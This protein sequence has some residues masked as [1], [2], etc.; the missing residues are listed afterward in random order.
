M[1]GFIWFSK[2]VH[3]IKICKYFDYS[4][5]RSPPHAHSANRWLQA[6]KRH[7]RASKKYKIMKQKSRMKTKVF[8]ILKWIVAII[9]GFCIVIYFLNQGFKSKYCGFHRLY[10]D[11]I[12]N[13]VIYNFRLDSFNYCR[14]SDSIILSKTQ[15]NS[16]V[17]KWNNSYPILLCKYIPKF[18]L[19]VKMKNGH[20]RDFITNGLTLRETYGWCY[21]FMIGNDFFK[22]IW[23]ENKKRP[24]TNKVY[25]P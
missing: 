10:K 9:L 24:A 3:I 14:C 17:R 12:E 21:K 7:R 8:R 1:A 11:S 22:S 19:T 2:L 25:N 13:I 16:F 15:I 23:H 5:L 4:V 20:N 18:T 6:L